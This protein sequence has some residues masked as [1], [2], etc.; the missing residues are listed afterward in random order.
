MDEPT[1]KFWSAYVGELRDVADEDYIAARMTNR[2]GLYQ[3]SAWSGLQAIEKYLK[4]ILLYSNRPVKPYR[5]HKLIRLIRVAEKVPAVGFGLPADC[6]EFAEYLEEQGR[7]RY[8]DVPT[9]VQGV[10]VFR[11]DR[12]VW[13]VRRYC[14]DFLLLPGDGQRYPGE[15]AKRLASVPGERG[16]ATSKD[17]AVSRG[18]LEAILE[19]RNHPQR[20]HLVWRNLY[21]GARRKGRFRH[22]FTV[23]FKKPA[24][25]M[26]PELLLPVLERLVY[27]PPDLLP[28]LR[29]SKAKREK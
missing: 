7:N 13:H 29:E 28:V 4:A 8:S 1:R 6:L 18:H 9:Y 14:Q 21:Y 23:A 15:S 2:V 27:I 20:P 24:H 19:D 25:V 5:N 16:W 10:E 3:S 11:L 12:L 17:L 22:R 26:R